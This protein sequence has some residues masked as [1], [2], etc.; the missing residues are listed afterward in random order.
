MMFSGG[1]FDPAVASPVEKQTPGVE[2][3]LRD[4]VEGSGSTDK[5]KVEPPAKASKADEP[6]DA[7][8]KVDTPKTDKPKVDV[9]KA[10]KP[11]VD[12]PKADKPAVAKSA[13]PSNEPDAAKVAEPAGRPVADTPATASQSRVA[14][15]AAP[16]SRPNPVLPKKCGLRIAIVLDLSGSLED[17]DVASSKT[18]ARGLV[19]AL[20]GTPSSVGVYT[21]ATF[22]PDGANSS[23][24]ATSV[25]TSAGAKT[26]K[27]KISGLKRP[28]SEH[29]GTNWDKGLSQVPSGAY[30]LILFVT[31]GNPTAYGTPANRGDNTD[32]GFVADPI[33]LDTAVSAANNHKAA[34]TFVMGLAVGES[35]NTGNIK[36]ISGNTLNTDYFKID[37]YSKL[38]AKLKEIALTNCE[39]T[40]TVVKQVRGTDD[41]LLTAAGWKFS[42]S[43]R[44]VSPASATTAA[45]GTANFE[46]GGLDKE[47]SRLVSFSE[48]QKPGFALEQQLGKNAVCVDNK[49][50]KTLTVGNEGATGFNVTVTRGAAVSCTVIN[51]EQSATLKLVKIV[52]NKGGTGAAPTDWALSAI[53][54]G[55]TSNMVDVVSETSKAVSAGTYALS[56]ANG[57]AGYKLTNL[58]CVNGKTPVSGVD[59][60][61]PSIALKTGDN[62][63]CTFTNTKIEYKDL[64][65][66]KTVTGSF[67]RDYDW[68]IDKK[69]VGGQNKVTSAT[70]GVPF[71]YEV[72]VAAS[73][74]K[75]SN[76]KLAGEITVSNPNKVAF[77]SVTV[78]DSLPNATCKIT[79]T[80]DKAVTGPV[81]IP[82]G[83]T[84][85]KYSCDMPAGTTA[86]TT[87]TNTAIAAWNKANY[88]GTSGNASGT[89]PFDFSKVTPKT[90]DDKITVTDD[91]FNLST[92]PGGNV[93]TVAQSPKTFGYELTWPGTV[94]ECKKYTNTASFTGAGGGSD[95]ETVELCIGADLT[96]SKNVVSSFDRSYLWNITK[97]AKGEA[98][99]TADPKTGKVSVEYDV[100][101]APQ[102]PNYAD[103]RWAMSGTVS[104][105]NPNKWQDVMATVTDSVDVGTGAVCTV[106]GIVGSEA[107]DAD[108]ATDGFQADIP[109]NKTVEFT[110]NCSFTEQPNYAGSNTA[111]V[112]WDATAAVTPNGSA[113]KTVQVSEDEWVQKPL[114]EKIVVTDSNHTFDPAWEI[115]WS[116]GMTPQ[117]KTYTTEWTVTKDGTCQQFDNTATFTGKD[118]ATGSATANIEACR[119]AG[120]SVEKTANAGFDRTYLWGIEKSL[121]KGQDPTVNAGS[122]GTA[123]VDYELKVTSKGYTDSNQSLT[124]EITVTNTN[125]FGGDTQVTV[126]DEASINGLVCEIDVAQD[127]NGNLAGVQAN[128]PQA[129]KVGETWV[130]GSKAVGYSCD[131]SSVLEKDYTG[132]TNIATISWN[133]GK[134]TASSKPVKIDFKVGQKV[135]ET[136]DVLDN[137]AVAASQGVKVG[138]VSWNEVKDLKGKFKTFPY[139]LTHTGVAGKCTPFTNTAWV[140]LAGD[141]KNPSDDASVTVCNELG[142]TVSKTANASFDREYLWKL[143]KQA[144][145]TKADIDKGSAEFKY[146][147]TATPNGY[148]DSGHKLGGNITLANPNQFASGAITA[149]VSDAVD[150]K[151]LTCEITAD[152]VDSETEG[153][154]VLVPANSSVVLPYTCDG[155]F[156]EAGYTGTNTVNVSWT[157]AKDDV[158]KT[159]ATAAVEFK[160]VGSKNHEVQVFDDK[161]N[162]SEDPELLGTA[163]WNAEKTPTGFDAYSLSFPGTP[164]TCTD[165]TNTAIIAGTDASASET[166]TVCVEK[167]LAVSKV[168]AASYDRDYDWKVEKEADKTS[169][170][171]D[172]EGNVVAKYTV[173][174]TQNSHTDSNWALGGKI[175]VGNPNEFGSITA[176]VQ[177]QPGLSGVQCTIK[178]KDADSVAPGFQVKLDAGDTVTLDYTCDVSNGVAE[179]DYTG[180][181]NV[182]TAT[183]GEGRS[184]SSEAVG[185]DFALDQATDT[186]VKVF[187]DKT[188]PDAAPVELFTATVAA[189]PKS[190]S[191]ELPL[192]GT[193]GKCSTF[194]NTAV[195]EEEAGSNTD[196]TAT[197]AVEVCVEQG[198]TVVKTVNASF[199]RDYDW[200][201]AK[202]ADKTSFKVDGDGKATANY[203]VTA[204]LDGHTDQDWKM[205]GSIDVFNPNQQGE[206]KVNVSDVAGITGAVCTVEGD[207]QDVS[208]PAATLVDGN[209]V[210]GKTTVTY[211]CVIP[212]NLS[213]A[214]YSGHQNTALIT[215]TGVD[216]EPRT[217]E[218]AT[219]IEFK[220]AKSIDGTVTVTDDKTVPGETH[221]LGT[222]GLDESGQEFT[223]SVDLSGVAGQCTTYTNNAVLQEESGADD[224]N[225]AHVDV[226]VCSNAGLGVQKSAE[227]SFDREYL[228]KLD[229]KA[230]D[231]TTVEIGLDGE[232]IFDYTVTATPD[233]FTDSAHKLGGNITLSNPNQFESGAVTATV[234]DVIDIDG[235]VCTI[236][237]TDTDSETDGLQ[238][239]VP[240][241]ESVVLPYTC[242]GEF[243]EAGYTGTNTVNV[244]WADATG[245]V[246][247]ASA[248]ADVEFEQIGSK[249]KEVEVFDDKAGTEEAPVSLG[250]AT[251]NADSVAT[252]FTYG[253]TFKNTN[254]GAAD[255]TC[256]EYPNIATI[257]AAGKSVTETVKVCIEVG[258]P[259][260]E[261]TV[262]G[263]TQNADGTWSVTYDINVTG[264]DS[265]A[266]RYSL[267]DT[268]RFGAG[269]TINSASWTA[270]GDLSGAWTAPNEDRTAVLV[271]DKVLAAGATDTYKVT[272]VASLA[273]GSI[274][275]P[276]MDCKPGEGEDG[277]TG[278]LNT[279][280]LGNDG[281]TIGEDEACATPVA[282]T[283]TKT[284]KELVQHNDA[285]GNW[286]GTFD[287]SYELKVTNPGTEGQVVD[288]SLTDTPQFADGVTINDR[289]VVSDAGTANTDWNG[290]ESTTDV[291]ANQVS[292]KAGATHLY[293]VTINV[294]LGADIAQGDRVCATQDVEGG[295]GLLNSGTLNSGNESI[296][297]TDCLVI[298]AP[299][300]N[301]V[302]TATGATENADGSWVVGY[303]VVVNNNSDVAT[304]YNLTDT[305]RF[306]KGLNVTEASW[307]LNDTDVSGAWETPG[308]EKSE[309]MAEGRILEARSSETYTVTVKVSPEAGSIGSAA[310]TC[311]SEEA[312]HDRGF[313]NEATLSF[314]GSTTASRDC[315]TPVKNP[316]SYSM[317]KTSDPAN[318]E[319]V[320]PGEEIAYTITVKNT[321]EFVY[322]GAVITDEMSGWQQAATFN[323]GSLKLSGGESVIDGSKLVWTVGDLAVGE[324]KTLTYTV[325]VDPEMWDQILV[326]VASGN[327]DVPPS[328]TTHP[329]PEYHKLP[330]PPVVVDPPVIV[331]PP[332]VVEPPVIVK[333][334]VVEHP[335]PE[336]PGTE[337][338]IP[339]TPGTATE[340]PQLPGVE[341]QVPPRKP[342]VPLANTGASNAT[343]WILGSG[344]LVMLLGAGLVVASR[345]RKSDE[346]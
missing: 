201:I 227:A 139:T 117:T 171:V 9:P 280:T 6:K 28:K 10:D 242:N 5:N 261:K 299:E 225:T 200:K 42:S 213:E 212:E 151:G 158:A 334:P 87:G 133:E 335:T 136:V 137:K 177:D 219:D 8:P 239:L 319:T 3:Q 277:N 263:T 247:K 304:R 79:T 256:T 234:S 266:S 88:F 251:W 2:Q 170:K 65:V 156:S 123:D 273:E 70:S 186:E 131:A 302:K 206:M 64:T 101:V 297:D 144:D 147:V 154:Q 82:A 194:T 164:G 157:D 107:G 340:I 226:E 221:T 132:H 16:S 143:D 238:V 66:S 21:F 113:A 222:V 192:K 265:L 90:T 22:A 161:V 54:A 329:T 126:A 41:K 214:D 344:A 7:T 328:V 73:A 178:G 176:T 96:V 172:G 36:A 236:A 208:V 281:T 138:S 283:F 78:A 318:G 255:G 59:Q 165:Y 99:Y 323:E 62:V 80:D 1:G 315:V 327:G 25:S 92:L 253:L 182:A 39:G 211:D 294:S 162:Q 331:E 20:Q 173:T 248:T 279:V 264:D 303:T 269:A 119:T 174:A 191:Y 276:A 15:A 231:P 310:A 188:N 185:I 19:D 72:K 38:A 152:D 292:L 342:V 218:F 145:R 229:K 272:V 76:F 324:S 163:T 343:L 207:G 159:S 339:E 43:T 314:N 230:N 298:P 330:E 198:L 153:L 300:A 74:P 142:L 68:T 67:A 125:R 33:D 121:A 56:E 195:L 24:G 18:A 309:S 241:N 232:A 118:G 322:T 199:D 55:G 306:G 270:S 168:V 166:V 91:K 167:P 97:T 89:Q 32:F 252:D 130:D 320:W 338:E 275:T 282:P 325:T 17:S 124:G 215:W 246:A 233:G 108:L 47:P 30:D 98:P 69:V 217:A 129:S 93:V 71:K 224:N 245:D 75:D 308:T 196:N 114:N 210:S 34:G 184:A 83:E 189:S 187:D 288:Y 284:A 122:G 183:W 336:L 345:R 197:E 259:T 289:Q 169:F 148:K 291:V 23:L 293:T 102:D 202:Q 50:E 31:D 135:D 305:L 14:L 155:E 84:K 204:S 44:S 290:N 112:T 120:L 149:T 285:D 60:T 287:A 27:D 244:S 12:V 128:V 193:A 52:D 268:L 95:S 243:T 109:K 81:S 46:I 110:Y 160:Q 333:P 57:P 250:L 58:T 262:T 190:F 301:I 94:G 313:L 115:T 116:A 332:V 4:A 51:Q 35:I 146:T 220:Q 307:T 317:V 203:T 179:S 271:T 106:T 209:A 341:S 111:T 150:I 37:D 11:K 127:A 311:E 254:L 216:N 13:A 296:T 85:F 337:T 49:T 134:N 45:D 53:Q 223:Y 140:E 104:V 40:L 175:T 237:A 278:F 235:L 316:R 257:P 205:S 312:P 180:R 77:E 100:T 258:T 26:V 260:V 105:A 326:N 228:W 249:N 181:T 321:G 286:D 103:S 48:E 295:K 63:T 267:E 346:S 240:A 141:G 29:G 86:T 61:N 274:G